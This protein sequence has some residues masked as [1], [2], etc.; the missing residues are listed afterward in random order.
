M[1]SVSSRMT[2][3]RVAGKEGAVFTNFVS[4]AVVENAVDIFDSGSTVGKGEARFSDRGDARELRGDVCVDACMV[5]PSSIAS[6]GN[7]V[8]IVVAFEA[9]GPLLMRATLT[10]VVPTPYTECRGAAA[11]DAFLIDPPP[12]T[13]MVANEPRRRCMFASTPSSNGKSVVL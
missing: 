9:A 10:F 6:R 12:V 13:A 7:K 8:P 3:K 4:D 1:G 11:G 5:C 2:R